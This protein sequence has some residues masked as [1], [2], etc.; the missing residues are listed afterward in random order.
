MSQRPVLCCPTPAINT[1]LPNTRPGES[2]KIPTTPG[3]ACENP[4][5]II[6][7][8]DA[9]APTPITLDGQDCAG[10]ANPATGNPGELVQIVQAPGQ[11]L[12]VRFCSD[13]NSDFEL[14]CGVDPANGHQVQ[15][16]YRIVNGTFELIKRWDTVTGA[17]WTGDATTLEGCGG[18]ALESEAIEMCDNGITFLRWHV[19]EDGIPTGQSIDTDLAG[20]TYTPTGTP[21]PGKCQAAELESDPVAVCYDGTALTMWV[22]KSSGTPTGDKYFTDATGADFT[23]A[24]E[25]LLTLGECVVDTSCAPVCYEGVVTDW[26]VPCTPVGPDAPSGLSYTAQPC[27]ETNT[28][29]TYPA[30][31]VSDGGEAVVYTF[32]PAVAG[33]SINAST[34]T[35]TFSPTAAMATTMIVVMATNSAGSASATISLQA[36]V[37][38][39]APSGL[40]YVDPACTPAGSSV[41]VTPT[42]ASDGGD[43]VG[44]TISP[45]TDVTIDPITGVVTYTPA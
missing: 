1:L 21:T 39:F 23:V 38:P 25:A 44:Y 8:G 42:L 2:N 24:D 34:G 5:Y 19:I 18:K 26:G 41:T 12:S 30:T 29:V 37:P 28:T 40:T 11:V 3:Y 13:D 45:T 14:S 20:A 6:D 36:C 15:T 22:I 27:T 35:L 43:T 4:L 16:A 33:A 7:C 32:A 10:A 17:E 31:L 9:V